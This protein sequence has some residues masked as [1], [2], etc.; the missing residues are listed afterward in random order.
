MKKILPIS[1]A[2][3]S[4]LVFAIS[5]V[6]CGSDKPDEPIQKPNWKADEVSY[7]TSMT[8]VCIP[9]TNES[10]SADDELSVFLMDQCIATA[11]IVENL[12][13]LGIPGPDT[14]TSMELRYYSATKHTIRTAPLTYTPDATLGSSSAPYVLRFDGAVASPKRIALH[15]SVQAENL[16]DGP[17]KVHIGTRED[18]GGSI[19]DRLFWHE[20]DELRLQM[21][22]GDPRDQCILSLTNGANTALADFEGWGD[23]DMTMGTWYV[24]YPQSATYD[25]GK[26]TYTIPAE[27]TYVVDNFADGLLP[28]Y[29]MVTSDISGYVFNMTP[30]AA[31]VCMQ[32]KGDKRIRSIT[33]T[34]SAKLS[35]SFTTSGVTTTG[36]SGTVVTLSCGSVPLTAEMKRFYLV[37]PAVTLPIGTTFTITDTE[38]N[39]TVKTL[40]QPV[41]LDQGKTINFPEL[42]L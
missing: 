7:Y 21:S 38:E 19:Y 26:V 40:N 1:L 25:L 5:L 24:T 14:L 39:T 27:Q 6:S 32:L 18:V 4:T 15:G 29:S 12:F 31:A 22:G 16:A 37:L 34:S 33:V 36:G 11:S 41:S 17:H 8:M 23:V 28:M 35:G 42:T 13:Y 30:V 2:L 3:L 10:I 9:P 20:G